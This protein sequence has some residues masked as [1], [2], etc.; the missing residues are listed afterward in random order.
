MPRNGYENGLPNGDPAANGHY[1][2]I[3]PTYALEHLATFKL[4]TRR[5]SSSP[6]RR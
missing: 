3:K 6:R 4:K 1:D 2:E 5:R